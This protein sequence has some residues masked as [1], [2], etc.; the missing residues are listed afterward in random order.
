MNIWLVTI[1]EPLPSQSGIKK[2]R[3]ALLADRHI[4]RNHQVVLFVSAFDHLKKKW[5]FTDDATVKI[6]ECYYLQVLKGK[7]YKKNVSLSRF[8][9]HRIIAKK[10]RQRAPLQA[11]PDMIVVSMPPHDLAYEVVKYATKNQIPVL[12]DIRDPW[13]DVFLQSFPRAMAKLIRF[14][15]FNEFNYVK[16]ALK[17]ADGLVA[18]SSTLLDWGLNYAGR[19]VSE[20]DHVFYLGQNKSLDVSDADMSV[21]LKEKSEILKDQFIVFFFGTFAHYHSP[22]VL[23]DSAKKLID[24]TQIHFMIAGDGELMPELKKQ[25]E[26]LQNVTL[27]GWL[28]QNEMNFWLRKSKVGACPTPKRVDI[29]PNKA[30]TYLSA[31]LPIVSSFQGDLKTIIEK[32]QIGFYYSPNNADALSENILKLFNDKILYQRMSENAKKVFSDLFDA[33]QVYNEYVNHIESVFN[34][35]KSK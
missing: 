33:E 9:D 25:S 15:L 18:T 17:L 13:P 5:I 22:M 12:V 6:S 16:N 30:G 24:N 26:N 29:L 4:G 31:G 34:N 23:I 21:L 28:D 8:I 32:E 19:K 20:K 11:K 14:V 10:F 3:T 2:L 1:G 35:Y 27:T 7:G